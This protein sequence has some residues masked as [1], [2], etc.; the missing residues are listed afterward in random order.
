MHYILNTPILTDYG[1]YRFEKISLEEA[2]KMAKG[3]MSAVGHEGAAKAL[4]VLLGIAIQTNRQKVAL[5]PG[6]SAL[7]F[8]ILERLPE[9]AVL[10]AEETLNMP[11]EFGRLERIS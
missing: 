10:S 9:G 5:Q 4:S 2:R 7:V 6:D 3:A 8:K 11:Y 1:T